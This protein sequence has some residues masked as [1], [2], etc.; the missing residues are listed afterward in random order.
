[1]NPDK[2]VR[3]LQSL[4]YTS[5]TGIILFSLWS[6]IRDMGILFDWIREAPELQEQ[7]AGEDLS[8]L[9]SVLVII[10]TACSV[11]IQLYIGRKA[12][13]ASLG[14]SKGK[15]YIGL[16]SILLLTSLASY[17]NDFR[18]HQLFAGFEIGQAVLFVID[19]TSNLILGEVVVCS[20]LLN[21]WRK[22]GCR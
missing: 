11:A 6:G 15:A 14:K 21:I 16:A 1:M 8:T 20:V 7:L 13:Q 17:G 9:V 22:R 18:N 19:L 4:L 12:M 10:V 2:K 5:G 3:R